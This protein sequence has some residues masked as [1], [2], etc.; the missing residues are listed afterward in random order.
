MPLLAT[1]P[2]YPTPPAPSI[3]LLATRPFY[4][5]PPAPSIPLL[6]TRPFYPTPPAS[7]TPLLAS[8]PFYPTPPA[9]PIS[10]LA[11]RLAALLVAL[12]MPPVQTVCIWGRI[13]GTW[14]LATQMKL[15]LVTTLPGWVQTQWSW[16]I[17]ISLPRP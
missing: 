16:A 6:A 5:T 10:L 7:T 11:G 4:P 13:P 12:Q 14:L 9:P 1:R 15:L 2:F 3:P 8:G 17:I